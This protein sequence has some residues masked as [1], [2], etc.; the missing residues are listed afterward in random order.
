[1]LNIFLFFG[2]LTLC[3]GYAWIKGAAPER[4]A[5]MITIAGAVASLL[6]A[7][8]FPSRGVQLYFGEIAWTL[9]IDLAMLVSWII[10]AVW[11]TR[12]WPIVVAACQG[13]LVASN[14]AV[15]ATLIHPWAYWALQMM[16]SYPIPLIIA[17]GAYRH[18]K[19]LRSEGTDTSWK[20]F[21]RW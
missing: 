4:T 12:Y 8:V 14:L 18:A 20:H 19:R 1:M 9:V 21:L 11:S 5:A 13:M 7:L 17:L 15:A 6:A 16:W 2:F 10:L 3:C